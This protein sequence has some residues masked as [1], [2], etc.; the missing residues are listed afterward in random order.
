[1][2]VQDNLVQVCMMI[3]RPWPDGDHYDHV[4]LN[5][6]R[7]PQG[8]LVSGGD[9]VGGSGVE[10][11]RPYV[12][13]ALKMNNLPTSSAYVD[14]WMRQIQTESG[15]NPLAIGGNDGLAD[16]NATGLLPK[17]NRE[18]LL[19]MLFQDMAI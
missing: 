1:M 13:R 9:S 2:T 16:G 11:W 4:H 15:G 19:R 5:G 7:D 12:K 6:V 14:A 8:G 17:Q 18:H 3:G 10:R